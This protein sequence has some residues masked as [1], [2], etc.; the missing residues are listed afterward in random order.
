MNNNSFDRL[1]TLVLTDQDGLDTKQHIINI[2]T[3]LPNDKILPAIMAASKDY[4]N[5]PEGRQT[6]EDN[7]YSFNF[8]D[9]DIYVSNE[10]CLP[11]GIRRMYNSQN[12]LSFDFNTQLA[13]PEYIKVK[14]SNEDIDNIMETAMIGCVHWCEKVVTV[15]NY[16]G[17]FASEQISRNGSIDFFIIEE[18]TP[19]R[20]DKE[21][22]CK[23]LAKYLSKLD[24]TSTIMDG[25]CIDAAQIDTEAADLILQYALFG[26]LVYS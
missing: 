16:L 8:G 10:F 6:W 18:N 11:H 24:D 21:K 14:V 3:S 19:V 9:F 12:C 1:V 25:D 13:E 7:N 17:K 20:L 23:G 22:F 5:T 2:K 15:G 26:E 4:L